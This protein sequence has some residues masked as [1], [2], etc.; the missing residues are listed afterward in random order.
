ML[1]RN[2]RCFVPRCAHFY[3]VLAGRQRHPRPIPFSAIQ[4]HDLGPGRL[5]QHSK[6]RR[7]DRGRHRVRLRNAF[8]C[9][10]LSCRFPPVRYRNRRLLVS[11]RAHFHAVL[12]GRQRHPRPIRFPAVQQHDL[13]PG[14]LRYNRKR[15][16]QT[17]QRNPIGTLPAVL[18]PHT[19]RL[20][21][22]R[23]HFHSIRTERQFHPRPI[24]F[25]A[26]QQH[27]L[28]ARRVGQHGKFRCFDSGNHRVRFWDSFGFRLY[29]LRSALVVPQGQHSNHRNAQQHPC[30]GRE[31]PPLAGALANSL[32]RGFPGMPTVCGNQGLRLLSTQ[33]R[34]Q[35]AAVLNPVRLF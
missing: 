8:Q 15:G 31:A 6:T 27:N 12:A 30:R 10:P 2:C 3:A 18:Y 13:G 4:Q 25:P 7:A 5:R 26:V 11:R 14:R 22:G 29:W 17:L 9:D 16:C 34:Q 33:Q 35:R 21:P 23:A 28:G 20:V 1:N 19:P 32:R 24:R